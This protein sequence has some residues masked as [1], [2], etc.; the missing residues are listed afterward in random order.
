MSGLST[1]GGKL[2]LASVLPGAVDVFV[3][4]F[5]TV[6][7][8][9]GS[10][11]VEV[12]AAWYA[13]VA[14][15]EW[16]FTSAATGLVGRA[17]TSAIDF[18]NV[19]VDPVTIVAWGI[20]DALTGGNLLAF[21]ATRGSG[22]VEQPFT[23]VVGDNPRFSA[24]DLVILLEPVATVTIPDLI[25]TEDTLTTLDATPTSF[26]QPIVSLADLQGAKV[27]V[28]V[29]GIE[30]GGAQHY[31]RRIVK[32]YSRDDGGAGTTLWNVDEVQADGPATRVGFGAGVTAD[33]ILNGDNVEL[34]VTGE[35]VT[36]VNW[37]RFATV[38]KDD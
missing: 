33:L 23:V 19:T 26:V 38:I 1:F 27:I 24:S 18:P 32:K 13:R 17:N 25:S 14:H 4:L 5:T 16:F 10:N 3:A 2:A 28:E 31:S 20:F 29:T 35:A 6:P 7:D 34:Q 8:F 30:P 11:G 21:D 36:E 15:D 37:K 9:D 12:S 22:N